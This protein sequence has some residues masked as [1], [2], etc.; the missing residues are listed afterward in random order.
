MRRKNHH[1]FHFD[2][3]EMRTLLAGNV[4]LCR[5]CPAAGTRRRRPPPTSGSCSRTRANNN[6]ELMLAQTAM[7]LGMRTDVQQYAALLLRDHRDAGFSLH[8]FLGE[9]RG[10]ILP[11]GCRAPSRRW[12]TSS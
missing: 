9:T 3:L 4:P 8:L 5:P 6:L 12:P 11:P 1:P 10:A 2:A 7:I